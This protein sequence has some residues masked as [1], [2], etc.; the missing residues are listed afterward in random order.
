MLLGAVALGFALLAAALLWVAARHAVLVRLQL[1]QGLVRGLFG[2]QRG[3]QGGDA[4]FAGHL[5]QFLQR[6]LHMLDDGLN[7]LVGFLVAAFVQQHLALLER[8]LL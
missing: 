7:I 1:E 3:G 5:C 8:L 4:G 6:T 2:G